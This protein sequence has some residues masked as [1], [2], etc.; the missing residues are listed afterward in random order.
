MV[1]NSEDAERFKDA[2][3]AYKRIVA[4]R[5]A[6]QQEATDGLPDAL[7]AAAL[8]EFRAG[9]RRAGMKLA[10]ELLEGDSERLSK[11]TLQFLKAEIGSATMPTRGP[12]LKRAR[13]V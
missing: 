3:R 7:A 8:C 6:A 2:A 10:N 11:K 4:L 12:R 9:N 13:G 1:W 5:R